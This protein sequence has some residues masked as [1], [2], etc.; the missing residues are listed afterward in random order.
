MSAVHWILVIALF[1]PVAI[2]LWTFVVVVIT[3]LINS[4]RH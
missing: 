4:W 2:I 3:E 1:L